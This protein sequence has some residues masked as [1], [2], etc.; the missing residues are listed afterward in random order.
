[1]SKNNNSINNWIKGDFRTIT[2]QFTEDDVNTFSNLTGDNNPLHMDSN[3]ASTTAAGG[4]VVHGMLAASF[5]S[6]LVGVKIPGQ[7]A[8][9]NDFQIN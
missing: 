9:W 2:H 7:G 6:T 5:I 4:R 8:L 3:Y 1:M